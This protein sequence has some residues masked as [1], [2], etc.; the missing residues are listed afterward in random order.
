MALNPFIEAPSTV[1]HEPSRDYVQ[2]KFNFVNG[3]GA[4]VVKGEG[5]YGYP[6]SWELAVL[7]SDGEL[8]Y[9]TSITEDVIAHLTVEEV[10][11]LLLRIA[12]L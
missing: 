3:H 9:T 11:E 6:N 8:D 12:E 10:R 5:T 7:D 2:Y 1:R 4:S